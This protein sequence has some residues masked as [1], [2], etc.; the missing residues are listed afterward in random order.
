MP[1]LQIVESP[2]GSQLTSTIGRN[3][4]ADK[5]DFSVFV[6]GNG[7]F[8]LEQSDIS[9]NNGGTVQ[10]LEGRGCT[11]HARIRPPT[12]A[13]VLRIHIAQN[14]VP[15]GNAAV[16]KTVRVS[17]GFPDTDAETPSQLFTVSLS[18]V[19]GIAVS[20]T[21]VYV[22]NSS[23]G[24]IYAYTHRG[25]EQVSERIRG[26]PVSNRTLD[27]INGDILI[28][29]HRV[30]AD[31]TLLETLPLGTDA[32]IVHTQFGF[33]RAPRAPAP[34]RILPYGTTQNA[35][36]QDL[37]D[38]GNTFGNIGRLAHQN[39]SVYVVRTDARG[40]FALLQLTADDTIAFTKYLNIQEGTGY[41]DQ[42]RDI[43][44]YRDTFYI[45]QDNGTTGAV[46]TLDI[47]KYRPLA[48]NTKKD[49]PPVIIHANTTI[50]LNDYSPDSEAFIFD[51]GFSKPSW[52][53][54][55]GNSLTVNTAS[56][57]TTI[58]CFVMLKGLNRIDHTETGTF[59]FYLVVMPLTA[60][61]WKSVSELTMRANA[62]YNLRQLVTADSISFRAGRTQPTGSSIS[63][64]VFTIGT[65]GGT[66]EF[67][68][69]A[70]GLESHIT[71]EIDVIQAQSD[72]RGARLRYKVEIEGIDVSADL[73][74][75]PRISENLDPIA[76][77]ETRINEAT[78]VLRGKDTYDSNKA[79]NFWTTHNLN[80]GGFQNAIKV[81]TEHFINNAWV[82]NLLFSGVI[83]ESVFPITRAEFRM[84]CV[85][86][87]HIL[88]NIVPRPFGELTKYAETR[89]ATE[90]ETYEGTYTPEASVL[91]IQPTDGEAWTNQ[92]GL[93]LSNLVNASEGAPTANSGY[94]T[95]QD[96]RTAGGFVETNPLLKY[97]TLPRGQEVEALLKQLAVGESHG[98]N[99]EIDL[100][101]TEL[102]TPYIL[103][104][105]SLSH[106]IETTRTTLLPV[107]WVYDTTADRILAVLSHPE[108]HI[109]SKIVEYSLSQ[110]TYRTLH[111]L[112]KGT[113]AHRI[114]RRDTT[115][116]YVLTSA[117]TLQDLSQS[118]RRTDGTAFAYDSRAEDSQC[119][120]YH[121]RADTQAFTSFVIE[122]HNRP[123]QVGVQYHIGFENDW[124]IDEFEG[125][126]PDYRGAF[127]WVGS[128][129]YYRYAKAREFGVARAT[130]GG[131]SAR[132]IRET[133]LNYHNHLNFAFDVTDAGTVYMV[134]A[135]GTA[136][137]STLTIRRRTAGGVV[138]TR[139]TDTQNLDALES[140]GAYL[141]A[142]ECLFYNNNLYLL[143]PIQR[144]DVDGSTHSRSQ[145]KAAKMVLYRCNVEAARPTLT[146]ITDWDFV[147]H[148]GCNLTVHNSAI[149]YTENSVASAIFKPINSDL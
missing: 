29:S 59:G 142:Y 75:A 109:Q 81:Y 57:T 146:K 60:P 16:S 74:N 72:L 7:N 117:E 127:A 145:A 148:S 83:L 132:R 1:A 91:P 24:N 53:S 54:I 22:S 95:T 76:V 134:S 110:N 143:V 108:K 15:E 102:A 73:L 10:S 6:T 31:G 122:S 40:Y 119:R 116:Y 9:V 135:K 92:T 36:I 82:E 23:P 149:H 78:V 140:G 85:D 113:V 93:T 45:L 44:I 32:S 126:R 27:Y 52:L 64:G 46:Y 55:R 61:A 37:N 104:R 33:L 67:T 141:G 105:G 125:I 118:P 49:I 107:D 71:L 90:E 2:I 51:E 124:Y 101:P 121:F 106:N 87:S 137:N 147:T 68:A 41:F 63:D 99:I 39:D 28:R 42:I 128:Y 96:F 65:E 3:D 103:N 84:N 100:T 43:A 8:T 114:A 38:I 69:T 94:L 111:T 47:K 48:K 115:N 131:V 25:T 98:Y 19:L 123:P 138:S 5:N 136:T 79:G 88:Q 144:T 35:N 139:L 80:A 17:T 129:L 50:D 86:A 133:T 97:H 56:I 4:D 70:N 20:P 18:S 77:N 89:K 130:S 34:F 13:A 120:I 12:T 14:A 112:P 58:T 26:Q 62:T 66:A 21:R 11:Y 30:N